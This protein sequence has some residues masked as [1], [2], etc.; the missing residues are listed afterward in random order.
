MQSFFCTECFYPIPCLRGRIYLDELTAAARAEAY[1]IDSISPLQLRIGKHYS[2]YYWP[3]NPG[4]PS[5]NIADASMKTNHRVLPD[6]PGMGTGPAAQ[7]V[8]GPNLTVGWQTL[9]DQCDE[10]CVMRGRDGTAELFVR[11]R[12]VNHRHHYRTL[13]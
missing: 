1:R 6:F 5:A 8:V 12:E 7:E 13:E 11:L 4:S 9:L 2:D 3:S 10:M